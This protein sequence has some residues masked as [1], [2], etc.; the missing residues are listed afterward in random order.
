MT[1]TIYILAFLKNILIRGSTLVK[2]DTA[3]LLIKS[4]FMIFCVKVRDVLVLGESLGAG[5]DCVV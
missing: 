4:F 5:R 3:L 1:L 2:V